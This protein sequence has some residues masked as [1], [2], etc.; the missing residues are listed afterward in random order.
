MVSDFEALASAMR[1]HAHSIILYAFDLMHLD[2]TD[3]RQ[4]SLSVRRSILKG[5]IGEDQESRLQFQ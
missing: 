5:L 3:L 1:C 4:Q 2:G